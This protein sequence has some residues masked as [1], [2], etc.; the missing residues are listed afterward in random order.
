MEVIALG[1]RVMSY[2]KVIFINISVISVSLIGGRNRSIMRK[3]IAYRKSVTT[4]SH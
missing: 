4:L 3:L 2:F 1:L